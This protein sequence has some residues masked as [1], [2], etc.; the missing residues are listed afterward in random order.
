M[1]CYSKVMFNIFPPF[2]LSIKVLSSRRLCKVDQESSMKQYF[3]QHS[4]WA[5]KKDSS[6]GPS[7]CQTERWRCDRKQG[8]L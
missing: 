4:P 3:A 5:W 2:G 8:N 7:F 6:R 1:I